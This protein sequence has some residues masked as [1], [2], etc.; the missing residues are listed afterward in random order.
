MTSGD[1]I[2]DVGISAQRY[3]EHVGDLCI[4]LGQMSSASTTRIAEQ[5]QTS[6]RAPQAADVL[7]CSGTDVEV[8]TT[9]AIQALLDFSPR[10]SAT[11]RTPIHE[12]QILLLQQIDLAWW[13]GSE[14]FATDDQLAASAELVDL[15]ALRRRG[16]LDFKFA[17]A[18]DSFLP[19]VYKYAIRRGL[20]WVAPGTPGLSSPYV[21]PQMVALLNEI[22]ARFQLASDG[23][24]PPLWVNCITRTVVDQCR[25]QELGFS[26]HYPSAHCR[27]WAADIEVGWYERF[28]VREALVGVLED[29]RA[30]DIINAIDEGRIWHVSPNP[31]HIKDY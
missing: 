8:L 1:D 15:R 12:V 29:L 30:R 23:S 26:A 14:D 19:R 22:A 21:R 28:G 27:G 6:L 5:I 4:R 3:R 10:E 13:S 25:L 18:S 2:V 20:P 11:A 17:I 7:Q 9:R 24:A 31:A 16:E